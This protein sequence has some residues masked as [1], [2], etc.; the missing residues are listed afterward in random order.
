MAASTRN[1]LLLGC[2]L[3][4]K[5]GLQFWLVSPAYDLH[6]DEYLHLDQGRH[7]AWGYL[8]VPPLTSWVSY[9]ILLLGNQVF[10]VKF[11]PALFGAL[12]L[13]V[14]WKTVEALEGNLLALLL[15]ASALTF[16]VLLRVNMLYQPNSFDILCWTVVYFAFVK[17]TRSEKNR[18]LWLAGLAFGLGLLNKYNIAF[19]LLG[20]LPALLLSE[21]RQV[22][23]KKHLAFAALLALGLVS[24]NLAWQV[25]HHF[26]ALH[27]L[28]EL[29]QTQLVHVNRADFL[30]EQ[31]I[32]F[33]GS[34]F[35]LL[36]AFI[37]FFRYPPFR[38]YRVFFWSFI[39]TL[40]LFLYFKAKAYYAI[41][42]Y[43]I[44]LAFGSVYLAR[45][46]ARDWKSY[47]AP[48]ALLCPVA[49]FVPIREVVFP[50]LPPAQI[51]E[52]APQFKSLNLLRWEDGRDHA[53][54]QDFADMLGWRELAR[55][56]DQA[57]SQIGDPAHTLVLCDNYGQAG[58]INY[59]T[60]HRGL[61]AVSTHADYI[62]WFPL[63]TMEIRHVILVKE[64]EDPD[65]NR[66][67]EKP[68]FQRVSL[69]GALENTFAREKGTRI[70]LLEKAR[71]S[72]NER[73]RKEI[74]EEKQGR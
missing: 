26:P 4:L 11:F 35:L 56:V 55:K 20:F 31:V 49:A 51:Q 39:F 25:K 13:A 52:R 5:I 17:Y 24:P 48:V 34:V 21:H 66:E 1:H 40:A 59:Y 72:I 30:K 46:L 10:W 67:E 63:D 69:F 27:H 7:L 74:E 58:A 3:L 57:Y 42:L 33:F 32:Y 36:A 45:L 22:L 61:Q 70:Y 12:T 37:S 6:R 29:S 15:S 53:L 16:S 43:P 65:I 68:L 14:V 71:I 62:N 8:S 19:L 23:G 41:G 47:L 18:W 38:P 64:F 44:L 54:P 28:N 50:V 2:L 9:L 73:L 60:R